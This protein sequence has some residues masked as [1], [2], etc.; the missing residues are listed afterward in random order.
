MA[1]LVDRIRKEIEARL[2]ELRP[3]VQEAAGLEAASHVPGSNARFQIKPQ[4]QGNHAVVRTTAGRSA[5]WPPAVDA[6][7]DASAPAE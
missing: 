7:H 2:S 3:I 1:D 5:N 6:I 4:R